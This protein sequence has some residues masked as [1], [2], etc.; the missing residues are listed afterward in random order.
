MD[1]VTSNL[2]QLDSIVLTLEPTLLDAHKDVLEKA[3]ETIL[4]GGLSW[5]GFYQRLQLCVSPESCTKYLMEQGQCVPDHLQLLYGLSAASASSTD[6]Y[7]VQSRDSER[8]QRKGIMKVYAS[9]VPKLVIESLM[10]L[11]VTTLYVFGYSRNIVPVLDVCFKTD[12]NTLYDW[13]QQSGLNVDDKRF[14]MNLCFVAAD[15]SDDCKQWK[16]DINNG[17]RGALTDACVSAASLDIHQLTQH[18]ERDIS[19]GY[20]VTPMCQFTSLNKPNVPAVINFAFWQR[21]I[22]GKCKQALLN[23]SR[24]PN[25]DMSQLSLQISQATILPEL[26]DQ[27]QIF[28]PK[29]TL[30]LRKQIVFYGQMQFQVIYTL[31]LLTQVLQVNHNDLHFGN[32]LID[33]FY[34]GEEKFARYIYTTSVGEINEFWIRTPCVPRIFDYDMMYAPILPTQ[35]TVARVFVPYKDVLFW[36]CRTHH[37]LIDQRSPKGAPPNAGFALPLLFEAFFSQ[38]D[39]MLMYPL[40]A[41]N[42]TP[43]QEQMLS[44][45]KCFFTMNNAQMGIKD[46][47]IV[48]SFLQPADTIIR[49]FAQLRNAFGMASP[50]GPGPY[51][52]FQNVPSLAQNKQ[53][54]S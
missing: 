51:D 23:M 43:E 35:R 40:L 32:V 13:V 15:V 20:T 18:L 3:R 49:R 28:F 7:V 26:L 14:A 38:L 2:R 30:E 52:T 21:S 39:R 45:D 19:Y 22:L 53:L 54:I 37:E 25:V 11:Y 34:P 48:T 17:C 4:N 44:I 24:V 31:L 6:V 42:L 10:Y 36:A 33:D 16:K 9:G 29:D 1:V 47:A 27:L 50:P 46:P 41:D 8:Q 12:F 5:A